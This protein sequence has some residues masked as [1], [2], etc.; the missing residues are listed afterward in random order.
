VSRKRESPAK[1]AAGATGRRSIRFRGYDYSHSGAY[2][3]T[4]CAARR[5]PLFGGISDG[6]VVENANAKI[7]RDCWLDLPNHCP[8]VSLDAFV[9]MPDH[10]HGIIVLLDSYEAGFKPAPSA[11]RPLHPKPVQGVPHRIEISAAEVVHVNE[12]RV[13]AVQ[14]AAR[15]EEGFGYAS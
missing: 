13:E 3:V 15:L 6:R 9:M 7:V 11:N 12:Q 8:R 1:L 2:F 4:V 5:G 10:M 14:V